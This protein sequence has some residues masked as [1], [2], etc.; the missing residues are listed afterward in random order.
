MTIVFQPFKKQFF[1]YRNILVPANVI[2]NYE[3]RDQLH[4]YIKHFCHI[5]YRACDMAVV[6][7]G[8]YKE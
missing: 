1:S 8:T 3:G 5:K 7:K 2:D 4:F 6:V